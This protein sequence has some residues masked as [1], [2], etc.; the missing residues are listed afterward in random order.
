MSFTHLHVHSNYSFCRGTATIEKLCRKAGEMGYTHLALTDTNGLY[1][2][3]WFL[4]AAR[5]HHLQPIISASLIS[6]NQRAVM[7]AKNER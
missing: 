2:M 5:A 1:G 3:G 4:A 6:D 7:L